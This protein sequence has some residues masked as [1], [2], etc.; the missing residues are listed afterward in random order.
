MNAGMERFSL[1]LMQEVRNIAACGS[2]KIKIVWLFNLN[3]AQEMKSNACDD[4]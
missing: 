1:D 3:M 4:Q 2:V